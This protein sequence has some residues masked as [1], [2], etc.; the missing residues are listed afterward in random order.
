ML[1][2]NIISREPPAKLFFCHPEQREG[3]QSFEKSRFF[4]ALRMTKV[5]NGEFCKW[6]ERLSDKFVA[7][8]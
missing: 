1:K 5:V 7:F 4:A 2:L 6:L 8:A 3:S